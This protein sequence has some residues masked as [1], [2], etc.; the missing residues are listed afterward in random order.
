VAYVGVADAI[1]D[2][3][4]ADPGNELLDRLR[5]VI[6]RDA[7][8]DIAALEGSRAWGRS[9]LMGGNFK[10]LLRGL[11]LHELNA[12]A[13]RLGEEFDAVVVGSRAAVTAAV[14]ADQ[15]APAGTALAKLAAIAPHSVQTARARDQVAKAWV[16][17]ARLARDSGT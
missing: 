10:A 15:L 16:R 9:A 5:S 1:A 14:T 8:Q 17:T 13:A 12:R 3:A 11:G 6:S 4:R 7:T 2:L